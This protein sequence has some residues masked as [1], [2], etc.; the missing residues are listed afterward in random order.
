[1]KT[2]NELNADIEDVT[3]KIKEIYPEL[4]EF[5][6]EM[7]SKN[8]G[9]ENDGIN[10]KELKQYNDL[11]HSLLKKHSSKRGKTGSKPDGKTKNKKT[12]DDLNGHIYPQR[13]DAYYNLKEE[14]DLNPEDIYNKK[15]PNEKA[16]AINEKDFEDDV[17]G[18]D[19]DIPGS[20]LD[21]VMEN[22]GSEDEEN[23]YYSIGGD[24]HENLE[25]EM[26]EVQNEGIYDE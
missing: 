19:L 11:L 24:D 13:E 12:K 15:A 10:I 2:V 14:K 20:E 8:I 23:N 1:M 26:D 6:E 21:D 17:T 16:D 4:L 9:V 3:S 25:E 7:P 22:I 18:S 5:L